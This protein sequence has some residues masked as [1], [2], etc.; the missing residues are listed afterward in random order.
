MISET[1]QLVFVGTTPT[2]ASNDKIDAAIGTVLI[3]NFDIRTYLLFVTGYY[4][5]QDDSFKTGQFFLSFFNLIS[6]IMVILKVKN[7]I[8]WT[9]K[10]IQISLKLPKSNKHDIQSTFQ[11]ETL[12]NESTT[13]KKK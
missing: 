4:S 9:F 2:L 7:Q 11:D 6:V 8:V 1:H 13:K 5:E 3:R 10:C 12:N